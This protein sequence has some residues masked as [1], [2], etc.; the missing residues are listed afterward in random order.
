LFQLGDALKRTSTIS[1]RFALTGVAAAALWLAMP[2]A[3][4]L[5]LGRLAVQSALGESL[6]AEI[7]VTSLTPEEASAL[8]VRVA[9]AE[10]YRSAGVD[11]NAVLTNTEVT[12]QRRA[13][14]RPYLRLSSDRPV[15]EPFV[16]VILEINWSTGRLVREYTLLFDPPNMARAPAPP[17][18]AAAPSIA[19]APQAPAAAPAPRAPRAAAAPAPASE[20][21]QA[22]VAAP[23]SAPTGADEYRVKPGDT[24]SRIA[25]RTQRGGVSLDQMLV[26]LY[27]ANTE[28]FVDNNMNRLKSGVVLQVP[29]AEQA[30]AIATAEARQVIQAQS[31]D[32]G[33]YRQRLAGAVPAAKTEAPAQKATGKVQAAVED[34]KQAAA[35]SPDKLT[36]SKGTGAKA[37]PEE[38]IAKGAEKKDAATR[39]AELS[40][41]VEELKKLGAA[42]S[43]AAKPGGTSATQTPATAVAAAP[44][45]KPVASVPAATPVAKAPAPASAPVAPPPVVAAPA[46]ASAPAPVAAASV[47]V[48]AATLAAASAP[49]PAASTVA[50]APVAA[51][52]SAAPT[53]P[54]AAKP[55]PAVPVAAKEEPGLLDS[56]LDDNPLAVIG[57]GLLIALLAAFGVYR[58]TKRNKKDSGETSFLE[59]RL[60]PDSFFGAS[61]GQRIDTRDA[62]GASSSMSYSLSQLDAI[63][64]VDP[65]AE[66]DVY[67][68]YGRDLQ[69]EE[70][71]KEAMRSNPERMAIRT[72][73]LEV[74]A[75]RRDIKGF[76]LLAT[77]LFSLTQGQGEDWA[78]AQE[79]GSQIDPDNALYKPGGAPAGGVVNNGQVVEPLGASTM[80]QSV[81]PSPSQFA[82]STQLPPSD[83][84]PDSSVDLDLDLEVT[85]NAMAAP[86]MVT[87]PAPFDSPAVASSG[88][89]FDLPDLSPPPAA[90]TPVAAP[91]PSV[92]FDLAGISLDLDMPAAA[93][94]PAAASGFGESGLSGFDENGEPADPLARKLELAEEFRQIGDM[95]GARDLLQEVIAK[96]SGTLKSK[97]QGMLDQLA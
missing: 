74:Y 32:F 30:K 49:A 61:G 88:M 2:N 16:D 83:S 48:P 79:L 65:V 29:S 96:A 87:A 7:D 1:G 22:A 18:P 44:V 92:D 60:Q 76:E 62:G 5:G 51:P 6:R 9:P 85:G 27:R 84:G 64:D 20:P 19:A 45:P 89:D 12:L 93:P 43:S 24:L 25:G 90:P 66:A 59:S 23:S 70:I 94:T 42:A 71:L 67:L 8:R 82:M 36:L 11:Y 3:W 26:S 38:Q 15:Q 37:A 86:A 14:G 68:A 39:V 33:A 54:V 97:A 91:T 69:A 57:G 31:A 55:A 52:A 81:L 34:R 47:P 46:V 21:R 10:S 73:L 72:K 56:L 13:D 58:F 63:G 41:N 78:K 75:K 53:P 50:A 35:P 77:Q 4:A 28:A 40:K 17:A 95:E 80:P